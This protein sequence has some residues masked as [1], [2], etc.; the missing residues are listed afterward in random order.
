MAVSKVRLQDLENATVVGNGWMA[1]LGE[2]KYTN[3]LKLAIADWVESAVVLVSN[4]E[5][6]KPDPEC[7]CWNARFD[8]FG[9][10][11]AELMQEFVDLKRAMA[12]MART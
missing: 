9:A 6:T 1:A 3:E 5:S 10:K 8:F 4:L 2:E 7:T 12:P 11:A